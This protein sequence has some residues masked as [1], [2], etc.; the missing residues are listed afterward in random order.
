MY[1][2]GPIEYLGPDID[3][4]QAMTT[5]ILQSNGELVYQSTYQPLT[6]EEQAALLTV[7]YGQLSGKVEENLGGKLT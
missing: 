2:C 5:K 7:R 4:C 1:F 6:V 3:M